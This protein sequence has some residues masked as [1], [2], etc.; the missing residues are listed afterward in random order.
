[1][2]SHLKRKP[3]ELYEVD[4]VS[5]T[6][7]AHAL[8]YGVAYNTL[9]GR[10]YSMRLPLEVALKMPKS[11]GRTTYE[12]IC[13]HCQ[14]K[15]IVVACA[16]AKWCDVCRPNR[17]LMTQRARLYHTTT[18]HL[19][20]VLKA[21]DERCALCGTM[22]DLHVD[23]DHDTQEIRGFLCITC[24]TRLPNKTQLARIVEYLDNPPARAVRK[25]S[26]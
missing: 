4:G 18:E 10:V 2:G 17:T 25:S 8:H 15:F 14:Q 12:R 9:R 7:R 3:N 11:Q 24:N 13:Q 20:A 6:L 22:Q 5:R 19:D 21:Q 16:A 26:S 1:M 23:H